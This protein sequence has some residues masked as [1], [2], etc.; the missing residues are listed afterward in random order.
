MTS[1]PA[2]LSCDAI[3]AMRAGK[4]LTKPVTFQ[5]QAHSYVQL[6]GPNGVGKSTLLRHLCGLV[7][8]HDCQI[9]LNGTPVN[10]SL[11]AH[12]IKCAYLGHR[13][14]LHP[15]LNAYE[16][17]ECLTGKDRQ[18][19]VQKPWFDRPVASYSAGQRQMLNL[20]LLD[21]ENDLWLLDEASAS[22]DQDNLRYLE[23][24]IAG[25]LA[26][27]GAVIAATHTPLADQLATDI[28]W[29]EQA[30]TP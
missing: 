24:R 21:D 15:D 11:I 8:H 1:L 3:T 4:Q 22:L 7:P 2:L 18:D 26:L 12:T 17:F 27:G 14:G 5:V 28:L 6:R 19:L 20:M 23:E 10:A 25:F 16:N 30:E 13:D 29:L 9:A